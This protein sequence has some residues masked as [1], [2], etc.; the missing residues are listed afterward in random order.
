[1]TVGG[2]VGSRILSEVGSVVVAVVGGIDRDGLRQL[3]T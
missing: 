1:M 3:A 2:A